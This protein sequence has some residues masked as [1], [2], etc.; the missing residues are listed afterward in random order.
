MGNDVCVIG[1]WHLGCVT[2]ACLAKLGN[3]V[4]CFDFDKIVIDNLEKGQLPIH[5][6]G[7]EELFSE[8]KANG[9]LIFSNDLK[10]IVPKSDFV[11]I[12]FDTPVDKNDEIDMSIIN[13]AVDTVIPLLNKES[14]LVISSQIPIGSSDE[15]V[16]KI[17]KAKKKNEVCYSPENL[18]LGNAINS[19][20]QPERIVFGLSSPAIKHKIENLF[21]GIY[22][23]H[24]FMS[25]K[26]AEMTKHA[27]NSYLAT[28]ISWSGEICNLCEKTAAN[29]IDVIAALKTEKRVSPNA[30]IMPGLG[31]GGG[32]LARDVQILRKL[33]KT[34]KINTKMFDAVMESNN[35]RMNY[36]ADKLKSMLGTLDK[37]KIA[38]LGLT[39]KAGTSTLR[40]SLALQVIDQI[41][42]EKVKISAYDPMVKEKIDDYAHIEVCLSAIKAAKDADAVVITTDWDE[43][44]SLNYLG[45][46]KV[47]KNP[48]IIDT[49]N[50]LD[51]SKFNKTKIKYYGVGVGNEE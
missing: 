27:M 8:A 7:L 12:A 9:S 34:N 35:E 33:G 36:V 23:K 40:R 46:V 48:V 19:F 11:Y 2:A 18:R 47:M 14:V 4:S 1:M 17:R 42:S 26:S 45:L 37:K 24:F 50:M 21:S 31:F 28:M 39:Y 16:K 41:K 6:P 29:A 38:F 49:K 25:L 13:K 20:M 44:K 51:S 43:F 22:A 10:K 15:I 32:T 5:E 30:P 3:K